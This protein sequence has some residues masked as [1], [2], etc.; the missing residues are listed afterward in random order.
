M[1]NS[2]TIS[3]FTKVILNDREQR[4]L[5]WLLRATGNGQTISG[6]ELPSVMILSGINK[7]LG[8]EARRLA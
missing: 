5:K 4:A 2:R 1:S 7:R 8:R 6:S 3:K